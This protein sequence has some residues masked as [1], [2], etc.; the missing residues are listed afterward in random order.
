MS[1]IIITIDDHDWSGCSLDELC[2]R[3]AFDRVFVEQCVE[4]GI[5]E[6]S[7]T[8]AS[9]WQFSAGAVLRLRKAW[10]LHR[11][12]D[13]QL[14][15]LVLILELLEERDRLQLEVSLLQQKLQKWEN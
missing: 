8:L 12:L 13:I 10:R 6:V 1:E 2:E 15:N 11:D 7:G 3:C 14:G 5:A 9:D 4:H